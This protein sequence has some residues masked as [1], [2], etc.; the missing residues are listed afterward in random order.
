MITLVFYYGDKPW[1][2]ETDIYGMLDLDERFPEINEVQK[3]IPNYHIN[4]I[5]IS[6]I[7]NVD[8]YIS[9]LQ[10]V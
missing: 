2:G 10:Y 4:L 1:D 3:F 9:D 8:N 7:L 5:D 6:N